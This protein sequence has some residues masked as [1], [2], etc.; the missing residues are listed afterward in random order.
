M[1]PFMTYSKC[2]LLLCAVF[3]S[4]ALGVKA[5]AQDSVEPSSEEI[6]VTQEPAPVNAKVEKIELIPLEAP[7]QDE[8]LLPA[9]QGNTVIIDGVADAGPRVTNYPDLILTPDKPEI[10]QL[11]V[12]AAN[13]IV[14]NTDNIAVIPDSARRLIIIPRA[15]GATFLQ[16]LGPDGNS[17]MERHVIVGGVKPSESYVR[18]R[19]SCINGGRGCVESSTYYCPGMC[20]QVVSQGNGEFNLPDETGI[21]GA[22]AAQVNIDVQEQG[23]G[24]G[25]SSVDVNNE[26]GNNVPPPALDITEE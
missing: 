9:R 15:A 26:L 1:G 21:S 2:T 22:P 23:D 14:G 25:N 10:I 17:V 18:I 4:F 3:L 5:F 24:R 6:T 8:G 12:D 20:H 16:I 19:R 7:A 11:D 13:I